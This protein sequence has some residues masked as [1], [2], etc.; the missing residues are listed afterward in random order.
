MYFVYKTY[1]ELK[2]TSW[3]VVTVETMYI[4]REYV[5]HS[6]TLLMGVENVGDT[7]KLNFVSLHLNCLRHIQHVF[8]PSESGIVFISAWH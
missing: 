5:I 2:T 1:D 4:T 8:I 7:Y 3:V 6:Q